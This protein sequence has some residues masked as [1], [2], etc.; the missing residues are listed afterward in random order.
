MSIVNVA[1][2]A[3]V[4]KSTVSRVINQSDGV[5]P[6]VSR[7]VHEA[8]RSLGY[9]PSVRRRGPK[10]LSRRGIRTGNIA[11]LVM[12]HRTADLYRAPVL[13]SLLEGVERGLT[14][15]GL[16][17]VLASLSAD[18][19]LPPILRTR[20]AD[21]LLLLGKW[22]GMPAA[23]RSAL[24]ALPTVW[25][26]REHSDEHC[27]FDHVFYRNAAVGRI[28]A[29]YLLGRGHRRLGFVN[30][31]TNHAAFAQRQHDFSEAVRAAAGAEPVQIASLEATGAAWQPQ[32]AVESLL[33]RLRP[34]FGLFVA[35][36]AQVPGVYHALE[37]L[38]LRPG[39]DVDVIGC[40]NQDQFLSKL[41]SRPATIDIAPQLVGRRG[42]QQLL[43]RMRNPQE[44]NRISVLVEPRLVLPEE[45][46]TPAANGSGVNETRV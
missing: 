23:V 42:V 29:R 2:L 43:W 46:S 7:A 4:S 19:D 36:D 35:A 22:D 11:M 26:L 28:A 30:V 40:D 18:E 38:G 31:E 44:R 6:A 15:N 17:L 45:L 1:N 21:G 16:N 8:M 24:R 25:V 32:S 27:E 10:P 37:S 41:P 9:Q 34:P 5:R 39:E 20:Q 13:P 14:E 3:G 33:A 12:G